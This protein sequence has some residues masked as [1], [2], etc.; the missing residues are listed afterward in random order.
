MQYWKS[1]LGEE[2]YT[3]I[4]MK[5]PKHPF[6][7]AYDAFKRQTA[8]SPADKNQFI[9]TKMIRYQESEGLNEDGST[10]QEY[11][12]YDLKEIRYDGLGNKRVAVRTNLGKYPIPEKV[13]KI[14]YDEDNQPVPKVTG[15]GDINTGYEFPF[16]KEKADELHKW[17]TDRPSSSNTKRTEY[18]VQKLNQQKISVRSYKDWL[19]GDFDTL[20][21]TGNAEGEVKPAVQPAAQRK[22]QKLQ[23]QGQ[24]LTR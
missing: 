13:T 24:V 9:V 11:I 16:T 10:P 20:Y 12:I 18:I 1:K 7:I 22:K 14:V 17:C 19:T 23:E 21:E 8:S 3:A 6:D 2:Q 5:Y 4:S 15:I